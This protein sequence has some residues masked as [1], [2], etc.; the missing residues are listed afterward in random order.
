[1][2]PEAAEASLHEFVKQAWPIVEKAVKFRDNWHIKGLCLHLEAV[3]RGEIEQLLVNVPPGTMKSLIV[4]VFW[5]CWV[6]IKN[7]ATRWMFGTYAV[8]LASRDSLR[9][10]SIIESE[11]YQANWGQKVQLAP[12]QN[13]KL[14][15]ENLERGWMFSTTVDGSGTGEHPDF[16][17]IDDPI[18]ASQAESDAFRERAIEWYI[19][20]VAMRG[21]GRKVKRVVVMQRL[22]EMDLAGFLL[23]QGGYEHF[24]LPM[25]FEE[26]RRCR[27]ILGWEDPRR[28]EGELLWPTLYDEAKVRQLE[29]TLGHRAAGQL[30][31]RPSPA[32]GQV[33]SVDDFRTFSWDTTDSAPKGTNHLPLVFTLVDG[34]VTKRYFAWECLW[35]QTCD[36]ASKVK[37]QN[38]YTVVGT[39]AL[40]PGGD[41]LVYEI[42]R[43]KIEIPQ[44][45]AFLK[46][47][48]GKYPFLS[49]QAIE[50]QGSGI[51]LIQQGL[52]DG[53]PFRALK[54]DADKLTRSQVVLTLYG[55]HKVYHPS[56]LQWLGDF[57]DELLQFPTG[58]HDDQVDVLSYAGHIAIEHA[59][60][61]LGVIAMQDGESLPS[62]AELLGEQPKQDGSVDMNEVFGLSRKA[63]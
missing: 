59:Q 15:F 42:T 32:R 36:T 10:R 30:Q 12:D 14:I 8:R 27:T 57:E 45:Y 51:G 31:Q 11:W 39:F 55:G 40:T 53:L 50:D 18:N 23:H 44:Q 46:A 43:A 62:L 54:A 37:R 2:K 19:N 33:F 13:Q 58:A 28:T 34:D 56:G 60:R 49:F 41:L 35:F 26:G 4:N 20:T 63:A 21:V 61:K 48:R 3:T 25:R 7:P 9:R 24:C 52:S 6:W 22:H 38:D 16:F 17:V 5:P 47:Q 1:M 29:R